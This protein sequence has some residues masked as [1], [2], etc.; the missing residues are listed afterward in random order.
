A[1]RIADGRLVPENRKWAAW[2]AHFV[3]KLAA[4]RYARWMTSKERSR[5]ARWTFELP[6]ADEFEKAARGAD[7]RL[8]PWGSTFDWSLTC[9]HASNSR[10]SDRLKPFATDCSPYGVLDLAGSLA[11]WTR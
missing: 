6:S 11:E 7:G 8:F 5:G 2:G 10:H 4:E 1:Y 9:T 3:S